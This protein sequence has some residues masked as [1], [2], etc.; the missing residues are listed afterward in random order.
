MQYFQF[1]TAFIAVL[2]WLLNN[3]GFNVAVNE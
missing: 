1:V 3:A 2:L